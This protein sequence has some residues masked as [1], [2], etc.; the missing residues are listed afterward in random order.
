MPFAFSPAH[1]R[2]S[3]PFFSGL[4]VCY[5]FGLDILN[6]PHLPKINVH[7]KCLLALN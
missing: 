6:N 1:S 2:F 7:I 4:G 5:V 3:F